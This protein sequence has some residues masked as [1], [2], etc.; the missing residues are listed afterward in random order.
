MNGFRLSPQQRRLFQ[1][2]RVEPDRLR[3]QGVFTLSGTLDSGKLR[4]ALTTLVDRYEILRTTF[5]A[6]PGL[7]IPLQKPA[8]SAVAE[9]TLQE[10]SAEPEGA[11]ASRLE[12]L[13]DAAL[14]RPADLSAPCM[15][16][17]QWVTSGPADHRLIWTQPALL[18]D[19]ASIALGVGELLALYA[20]GPE[21]L[22]DEPMQYA[23]LAQW[24]NE[25]LDDE[26]AAEGL[27][28]WRRQGLPR[29]PARFPLERP[30][31]AQP[32]ARRTVAVAL[33]DEVSARLIATGKGLGV[34]TEILLLSLWTSLLTRFADTP[35]VCVNTLFDGRSY[36]GLEDA[37]GL[38][39]R[40]LPI[41][42]E[43]EDGETPAGLAARL[44][45]LCDQAGEVQEYFST[46]ATQ[47]PSPYA[48]A[49]HPR[50]NDLAAGNLRVTR[51][52][53]RAL[54]EPHLLELSCSE[55]AER[56]RLELIYDAGRLDR[57]VVDNLAASLTAL[58]GDAVKR[59]ETP[60]ERLALIDEDLFE[61]LVIE[62][63]STARPPA[64]LDVTAMIEARV[65]AEPEGPAVTC[66][67][68]SVS[69]AELWRDAGGLARRLQDRGATTE[70]IVAICCERSV[71]LVT[72]VV[73]VLRSGAA[74]LPLDPSYPPERLE[75][76][77][78]DSG[79][80]LLVHHAAT[81]GRVGA[82]PVEA[83]DLAEVDG[84]RPSAA[85][86][87]SPSSTSGDELA[88]VIYTSGS[89]GAP[90]GVSVTHSNL[91]HSTAARL[92]FYSRA[93]ERF[94]L[95]S[96][97]AFDSSVVGLFWTLSTGGHLIL[98]EE[99]SVGD[100]GVLA[101]LIEQHGVTHTL[102]L[103]TLYAVLVDQASPE[104][105]ASLKLVAV[106][107][108]TCPPA[109]ARRHLELLT[110][111]VLTDTVLVN[112]YGP[113]EASVW[114]IA[115]SLDA[116]SIEGSV[117]IGGP[118]PY[119]RMVLLD[120]AGQPVPPGAP[121]EIFLGGAGITRGYLGRPELTAERFLPDPFAASAGCRLY[122]TGD[123]GRRRS[124]DAVE[125]LGRLDRQVKIRGYRVEPSEIEARLEDLTDIRQAV[126]VPR[127]DDSGDLRLVAYLT[128]SGAATPDVSRL[129]SALL[130]HLPI[131]MIPALFV[132]L[133]EMPLT[134]TGKLDRK[135]L[136]EPDQQ[137]PHLATE[138]EPA[139]GRIESYLVERWREIL[140]ADRIGVHDNFFELGGSS[141]QAAIFMNR[142][143]GEIDDF[144]QVGRLFEH[145]TVR[146]LAAYLEQ[147]HAEAIQRLGTG[148]PKPS[149]AIEPGLEDK[150]IERIPD[151]S[152]DEVD[153][154]LKDLLAEGA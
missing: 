96:S 105:L 126:V 95:L 15:L 116:A 111:T 31:R 8:D 5:P 18:G 124:D 26:D 33:S 150:T 7:E 106:A 102:C 24:L 28:F 141:I 147:E 73:G 108:E 140:G 56:P 42:V 6:V 119:A 131:Y 123:R 127:P 71:D 21:R 132:A 59:I 12:E 129:R 84:G 133:D 145:P 2:D 75:L 4:R 23:D 93:P 85:E 81:S 115:G 68:S 29:A 32:Y 79:A 11:V 99:G 139:Q 89:T 117:P 45:L 83:I 153:S 130:D 16:D 49:Y 82:L 17:L 67:T 14:A 10:V 74:Y 64:A 51:Q 91:A 61:R 148:A 142:I 76:M 100:V 46:E 92:S 9:I 65:R 62:P 55:G 114:A 86:P 38:F 154:M 104:Q 50:R 94:L 128:S 57:A 41:S 13:C 52:S 1:F 25:I 90:K 151:M 43:T 136:P 69:Y 143:R 101:E 3:A 20:G 54:L 30:G 70:T 137:R 110:G 80:H 22:V 113:T 19:A 152:D 27:R 63:A 112:E 72:A 138:Y 37:V 109:L 121:G 40:Y 47:P 53:Y 134:A 39:A 103:P 77:I 135:A 87:Q 97:Y 146:Q 35:A 60:L 125:L 107:G 66:G 120:P 144:I 88:Y 118:I 98:P 44:A 122:R 149:P 48:F 34:S 36:D 78:R 58:C